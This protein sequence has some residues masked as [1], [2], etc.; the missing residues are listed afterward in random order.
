[1]LLSQILGLGVVSVTTAETVGSVSACTVAASPARVT[2][3]RL[4]T[5]G[6]GGHVLT[7][8]NI[9]SVGA[10][11]VT[12]RSLDKIVA[13]K[14]AEDDGATDK[15]HDPMGRAVLTEAGAFRGAVADID[16]DEDD[17]R[18]LRLITDD[19]E[20]PGER[21]LGAGSYAVVVSAPD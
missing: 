2:G 17:G 3:L 7:W 16:F 18:I 4:K 21:L 10:D 20:I 15:S 1:M 14:D 9:R 13:E 12:V 6:R 19:E 11:A 5:R 8:D